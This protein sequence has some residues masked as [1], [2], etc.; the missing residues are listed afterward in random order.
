VAVKCPKCHSENPDT[1]KFC[2][3]CGT[4]LPP[5]KDIHPE[6]TET[7]Q[8]PVKELTTGSI[9]AN[10]YQVIEE[11][12]KGGMGR[13]YK[14]FDTEIKEK[15][16]LKLLKPEIAADQETIERFRNELKLAR[17]ISHHNICRMHDLSK[18]DGAYYITMEYISGEDLKSMIRMTGM[19]GIGTVLSV[20][21][22]ICEGLTEAHSLGVVHRDL[23]PQNIMTSGPISI[24]LGSSFTRWRQAESHSRATR[25]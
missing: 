11:L 18:E 24:H 16:A 12:G 7:L 10:R 22:Q 4:Q 2:G 21:E 1:V 17:K 19:L 14:V 25:H 15:V 20:G 6:V 8:T 9:F 5:P 13:V 3:E 23:K